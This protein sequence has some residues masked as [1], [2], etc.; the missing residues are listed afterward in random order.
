MTKPIKDKNIQ[1]D[2]IEILKRLKTSKKEHSEEDLSLVDIL[3]DSNILF[4]QISN[5]SELKLDA[6]VTEI[7]SD[8][9]LRRF[10]KNVKN[11]KINA[12]NFIEKV[13]EKKLDEFFKK[14]AMQ[15]RKCHFAKFIDFDFYRVTKE[16]KPVERIQKV[17]KD[18]TTLTGQN[19]I[20][21]DV[22]I[23]LQDLEKKLKKCKQIP[24]YDCVLDPVSFDKTVENIFNCSI[25]IRS[26]R[27]MFHTE[28]G[29][30]YL[31][32]YY[33]NE[34]ENIKHDN[35]VVFDITYDKYL[36]LI[37]RNNKINGKN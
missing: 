29:N 28:A 23:F 14:V 12:K 9:F 26:K 8:L 37:D 32:M 34:K 13:N 4:S 20:E 36:E 7:H 21:E 10:T 22:C 35:H 11:R 24:F 3:D 17:V 15:S 25:A 6:K 18:V 19:D 16:R 1:G 33:E 2:Y 31:V 27:I 5:T 30:I